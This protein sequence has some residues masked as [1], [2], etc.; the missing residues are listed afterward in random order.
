MVHSRSPVSS[1]TATS[2]WDPSAGRSSPTSAPSARR[3][4][5]KQ[6][7]EG[8]VRRPEHPDVLV[9]QPHHAGHLAQRRERG[10]VAGDLDGLHADQHQDQRDG[11]G[12]PTAATSRH[13]VRPAQPRGGAGRV[14]VVVLDELD[15]SA[16]VRAGP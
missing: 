13:A 14:D 5:Q 4:H 10:P 15:A 11:D 2:A 3:S 9:D 8:L 6:R 7:R 16:S 1:S 12:Q